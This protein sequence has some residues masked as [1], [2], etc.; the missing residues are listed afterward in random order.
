MKAPTWVSDKEKWNSAVAEVE[1]VVAKGKT[2]V[3]DVA[4]IAK[5]LVFDCKEP[6]LKAARS[7]EKRFAEAKNPPKRRNLS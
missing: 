5:D 4:I 3:K 2:V 6:A 7:F 1:N